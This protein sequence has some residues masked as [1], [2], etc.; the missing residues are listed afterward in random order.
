VELLA[1]I[2]ILILL[3]Y[4]L[5]RFISSA[6]TA[7]SLTTSSTEVYEKARIA[8]D[9]ITR[10]LQSAVARSNDMPGRHIR[11]KQTAGDELTFVSCTNPSAT[12]TNFA[13]SDF[14]EVGYQLDTYTL[15]RALVDSTD[16][17]WNIYE[18]NP[19]PS[20][21]DDQGGFQKVIGGVLSLAFVCYDD[22]MTPHTW[23]GMDYETTLPFAVQV[24]MRIM[25]DQSFKKWRN[26]TG[27]PQAELEDKA[28][29]SF[30]KMVFLGNRG[31]S[32][33]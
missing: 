17:S 7:W 26:L 9:V 6:Q 18:T 12:P 29:R 1:A 5:F 19:S 22:T 21:A 4:M 8:F 11:F 31:M 14:C 2:A 23:S 33:P 24:S 28:A 3:M 16:P 32:G 13:L 30:T 25:D 20:T 15:E 10:D 27:T